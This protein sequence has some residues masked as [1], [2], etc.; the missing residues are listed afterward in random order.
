MDFSELLKDYISKVDDLNEKD[1]KIVE[2]CNTL[3]KK[4]MQCINKIGLIRYNSYEDTKN[5]L[6]FTLALLNYENSGIVLNSIYTKDGGSNIYSKE[7]IKGTSKL[8]LSKEEEDAINK[9][10]NNKL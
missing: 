8:N 6:S 2:Y 5:K 1:N 3:N 4:N 10:I 7:I 9:A